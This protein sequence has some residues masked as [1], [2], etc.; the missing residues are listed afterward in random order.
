MIRKAAGWMAGSDDRILEWMVEYDGIGTPSK[1]SENEYIHMGASNVSRRLNKLADQSDLLKR[2]PNG[3]Y[4]ITSEGEAYLCG[5][6]N[7]QTGQFTK[8]EN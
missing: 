8:T 4:M 6:Y 1:I 7:V 3:V 2:L 5:E